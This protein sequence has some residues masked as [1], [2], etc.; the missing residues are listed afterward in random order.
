MA[1]I[2]SRARRPKSHP[3]ARAQRFDVVIGILGFFAVMAFA[4]TVT[5]ELQN[6]SAG[7]SA[8]TL[9]GLLVA[10]RYAIR[11]RRRTGI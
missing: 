7:F 1:G 4:Q 3:R 10:L 11:A 8:L 2:T 6:K 9:L 5:Y